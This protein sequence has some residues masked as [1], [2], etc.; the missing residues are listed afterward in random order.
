MK[1]NIVTGIAKI[2]VGLTLEA[3]I[4][5]SIISPAHAQDAPPAERPAEQA[6]EL[7]ELYDILKKYAL[8]D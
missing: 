8:I 4:G 5:A 7:Q 1:T 6:E 2:A 3:L